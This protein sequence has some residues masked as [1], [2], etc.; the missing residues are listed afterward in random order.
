MVLMGKSTK[1]DQGY[2]GEEVSVDTIAPN[3]YFLISARM[4]IGSIGIAACFSW[5]F[6]AMGS[7]AYASPQLVGTLGSGSYHFLLL[8]GLL[9]SLLLSWVAADRL[10]RAA[11][12]VAAFLVSAVGCGLIWLP[13]APLVA[14]MFGCFLFGFGCG[15]LY[16][17]YGELFS[18]LYFGSLKRRVAEVFLVSALCCLVVMVCGFPTGYAV[19]LAFPVVAF[20][21]YLV[22]L[23][24]FKP[25]FT[26]VTVRESDERC[27]VKIRSYLA[28]TTAGLVV[29]FAFGGIA[30]SDPFPSNAAEIVAAIAVAAASAALLYDSVGRN[31]LTEPI[32]M[33]YFLPFSA[34]VA[35][36]M[37]FVPPEWRVLFLILLLCGSLLPITCSLAAICCHISLF[38]LHPIR[39]FSFGR[40]WCVSGVLIGWLIAY[41]GMA[42]GALPGFDQSLRIPVCVVF[43]ILLVIF[44]ASFVMTQDNYPTRSDPE[45]SADIQSEGSS[46][47]AVV[48][49]P[50]EEEGEEK[51]E[52][53]KPGKFFLQCEVIAKQYGLSARQREVLGML[54]RGRNAGYITEKLIISAHTAKAH[55]YNI[56]QK[57]GVH[58]R[59]ELMDLVENAD[60]SDSNPIIQEIYNELAAKK[61]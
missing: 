40:F 8:A 18:L 10:G 49:S 24:H 44:S 15:L 48:S 34:V 35:L 12:S 52:K 1:G 17:L 54:A 29:G 57:T 59:Q 19:A 5:L 45:G 16:S 56:Y 14:M 7:D 28:T 39:S 37:M 55:I 27:R 11:F 46:C 43:F 38:G 9:C 31:R 50:E 23:P 47:N 41:I 61:S 30:F 42:D 13:Q 53:E 32:S 26:S 25:A 2:R 58:S 6:L 21:F 22:G 36:P 60:I 3:D 20:V 33:K 4:L 51:S